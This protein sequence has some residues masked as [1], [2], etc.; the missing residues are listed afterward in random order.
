MTPLL[1][2]FSPAGKFPDKILQ[3]YGATPPEAASVLE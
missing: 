2:N 1:L 3:E